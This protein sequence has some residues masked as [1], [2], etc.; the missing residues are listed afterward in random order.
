MRVLKD[1][2]SGLLI[3]LLE[4]TVGI[5]LLIDPVGFTSGIIVA[6]GMVVMLVGVFGVVRYFY[7]DAETAAENQELTKGLI[8]LMAGGFGAFRASKLMAAFPVLT[9]IYGLVTIIAGF[10]KVQWVADMIR[11]KRRRWLF[12]AISA[13]VSLIC[14]AVII[15]RPFE[16]T[17]VLW[18][19]TGISLIV[20]AAFDVIALI[21]GN[22]APKT[23]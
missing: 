13:A 2:G 21:F 20:G 9:A 8:L 16:T 23:E 1:L 3:S 10:V 19:F 17:A 22:R 5:L 7:T 4:L 18:M 15:S 12:E 11:Q 6:F 14:G